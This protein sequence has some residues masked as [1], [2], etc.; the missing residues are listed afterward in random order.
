[1]QEKPGYKDAFAVLKEIADSFEKTKSPLEDETQ[2]ILMACWRL[3]EKELET[4][5]LNDEISKELK[6]AKCVPNCDKMLYPPE[7]IFFENRAGLTEK[8]DGFLSNNVIHKPIGAAKAMAAA[9]VRPLS[10]AVQIKLL[11]CE[12]PKKDTKVSQ[13]I[14]SR[15]NA[16]GRILDSQVLDK[17]LTDVLNRLKKISFETASS[18]TVWYELHALDRVLK[19]EPEGTPA[20]YL[21][22][23]N[24][25]I[26]TRRNENIMWPS[27]SRELAIALLP[28]EDPGKIAAGIKEVLSAENADQAAQTLDELGYPKLDTSVS[29]NSKDS[30]LIT[31]LGTDFP[32][33]EELPKA[34]IFDEDSQEPEQP[35]NKIGAKQPPFGG[36]E[37]MANINNNTKLN[38][39]TIR[40]K[41]NPNG[42]TEDLGSNFNYPNELIAA[43]NRPEKRSNEEI[44][45]L[46][47][48]K[49]SDP[50]GRR[51]KEAAGH[52]DRITNEPA[53]ADRRR[54]TERALLEGPDEAVRSVL[55][56]WYGGKC[57]ICDNTFRQRN[58]RPFFIASYL[59]QR[60]LAR[61]VD[62]YANAICLCA[63][64]FARWQHGAVQAQ[65]ILNQILSL[66]CQKEGGDSPPI[67]Q[68]KLCGED[69]N[70]TFNE[71]HLVALQE[72]L[73]VSQSIG[74]FDQQAGNAV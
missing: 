29:A 25:L 50:E 13:L 56:E 61:Q 58:G 60:K 32:R 52:I 12:N 39:T 8:F 11:N 17:V 55:E 44:E 16:L 42:P 45:D 24:R 73:N 54:I 72:L 47:E 26:F 53:P 38:Q 67:V 22:D 14:L 40:T 49:V 57:Q 65:N 28:E 3:I 30:G 19:S 7:W 41:T 59:V 63:E 64:H 36:Q 1:V 15:L 71:K 66:K 2:A 70:I 51:E 6:A 10:T 9:G 18:L 23:G 74:E 31:T 48:G 69:R 5:H 62:N 21:P 46:D 4:E 34:P 37:K 68:I 20:L 43:F 33:S 27:L 35:S